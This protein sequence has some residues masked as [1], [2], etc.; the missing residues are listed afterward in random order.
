MCVCVPEYRF[1]LAEPNSQNQISKK[2][3][4]NESCEIPKPKCQ[5]PNENPTKNPRLVRLVF[6]I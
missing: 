1:C 6:V 3:E 2:F 4:K 5:N